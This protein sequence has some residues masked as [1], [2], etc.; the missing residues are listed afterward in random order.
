MNEDLRRAIT[1]ADAAQ[2]LH[3]HLRTVQRLI[4]RGELRAVRVGRVWR[5]PLA[6]LDE[7]LARADNRQGQ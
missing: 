5:V 6:A 7:Y 4:R 1:T 3:L 2:R